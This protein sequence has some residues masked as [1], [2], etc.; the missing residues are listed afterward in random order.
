MKLLSI[1]LLGIGILLVAIVLNVIASRIG[2]LSWFEFIKNPSE[3]TPLSYVWLFVVYPL[4]LGFTAYLLSK[5]L[6]L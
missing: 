3:A 4:G 6:N 1:F 2:L 5:F